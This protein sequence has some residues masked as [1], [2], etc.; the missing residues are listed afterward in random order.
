MAQ[1]TRYLRLSL[2]ERNIDADNPFVRTYEWWRNLV[3][4]S[5]L[6]LQAYLSP[7]VAHFLQPGVGP[8]PA[9][10]MPALLGYA[11]AVLA[12]VL[13]AGTIYSMYV[14]S[15]VTLYKKYLWIYFNRLNAIM[16][17]WDLEFVFQRKDLAQPPESTGYILVDQDY[18]GRAEVSGFYDYDQTTRRYRSEF[19]MSGTPFVDGA[20]A[21]YRFFFKTI[22]YGHTDLIPK[23]TITEGIESVAISRRSSKTGFPTRLAGMFAIYSSSQHAPFWNGQTFYNRD[24]DLNITHHTP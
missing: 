3:G 10:Q 21:S 12:F 5:A 13:S 2:H 9:A 17:Q 15:L 11:L 7:V 16:G 20:R 22:H 4:G 23:P 19:T 18:L 8:L 24:D 6:V 14:L 1:L